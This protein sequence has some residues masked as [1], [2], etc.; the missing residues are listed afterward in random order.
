LLII[1]LF[2]FHFLKEPRQY[3]PTEWYNKYDISQSLTVKTPHKLKYSETKQL[4]KEARLLNKSGNY[5]AAIEKYTIAR[6]LEPDNSDLLW[7]MSDSYARLNN[8]ERAISL[9]DTAIMMDNTFA[10]FYNNRGLLY[11]KMMQNDKALKDYQMAIQLDGTQPVFYS[12]I[13]LV[14]YYEHDL[15]KACEAI[16]KSEQLGSGLSDP[17]V[18]TIKKRYC[19]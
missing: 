1:P 11:Y 2:A 15:D 17:F 18:I 19:E 16:K 12:N 4:D 3:I 8:L 7:D 14:Y 6:K 13:A 9:L 5:S 10:P